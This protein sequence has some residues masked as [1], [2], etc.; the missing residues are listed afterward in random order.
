M[1]R[2]GAACG[3]ELRL[4]LFLG[5]SGSAAAFWVNY[6]RNPAQALCEDPAGQEAKTTCLLTERPP[7]TQ[8]PLWRVAW[9]SLLLL[10]RIVPVLLISPFCWVFWNSGG[11]DMFWCWALAALQSH[12]PLAIKF[13]QW[14]STRPD[15]LPLRICQHFATLQDSVKPHHYQNT[16]KAL[17]DAFGCEWPS[18]LQLDETPIGSGSMAQVYRG[19][20]L[21]NESGKPCRQ[22]AVKVRHPGAPDLVDMDLDVMWRIVR[23]VQYVW[24]GAEFLNM[25]QAL[26]C[27]EAFVRPQADLRIEAANLDTFRENFK[28]TKNDVG[29]R[30]HF[31]EAIRPY[32]A[33]AVLVESYEP[34]VPLQDVL[35]Q[36]PRHSEVELPGIPVGTSLSDLRASVGKDCMDMF[37]QM[38]FKDNFIHGDLHPGNI[39]VRF[40]PGATKP[41]LVVF[42]AGLAIDLSQRDRKNF[43]ELFHA[44]ATKDGHRAGQMMLDR[45][46]GDRS[47]VVD[48]S[49]FVVGVGKLID[50]F[51]EEGFGLGKVRL[52]Q[53]FS[54][55]IY[56]A[57]DHKVQLETSF[58]TVVTSIL[59]I[60]GVGRQLN[61]IVD[62][63]RAATPVLTRALMGEDI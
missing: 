37:L 39:H 7:R 56:L 35:G 4:V 13:A 55:I 3:A 50:G 12:G 40:L 52:G 26:R 18:R 32:V 57:C 59:V 38:L 31:P 48:P 27:F 58:V 16:E 15:I 11:E 6:F 23:A 44:V 29:P 41:D 49:G 1:I 46:Q 14:A 2:R 63:V 36:A 60:E 9:R 34:G 61:P 17:D 8:Y 24:P 22:I 53:V 28:K 21:C 33:E 10:C 25:S 20:L 47:Q 30:V 51:L 5:G 62:L 54:S 43:V 42:D 19:Q 45:M